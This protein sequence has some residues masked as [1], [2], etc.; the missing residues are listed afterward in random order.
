MGADDTKSIEAAVSRAWVRVLGAESLARQEEFD[1]AGG[2]SLAFLRL[3]HFIELEL[4]REIPLG[5]VGMS[6]T[7]ET[8]AAAIEAI[9]LGHGQDDTA[10][11]ERPVVFMVP[12]SGGDGPGQARLR[13]QC[14]PWLDMRTVR[15]PEWTAIMRPDFAF[16]SLCD[17]VADQID[18][19]AGAGPI[20]ITGYCFGG[21]VASIA[22][23][24]LVQRGRKVGYLGLVDADLAWFQR[25]PSR[26]HRTMS[27]IERLKSVRWA[28]QQGRLSEHLAWQAAELLEQRGR[29]VLRWM[30]RGNRHRVLPETFRFHLNLY[31]QMVL[32]P[33]VDRAGLIRLISDDHITAIPTTVFRTGHHAADRPDLGW[34]T[35]FDPVAVEVIQG[36]HNGVFD[37]ETIGSLGDQLVASVQRA[38]QRP[39]AYA[40]PVRNPV[41]IT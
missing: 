25:P 11:T 32:L 21:A 41:A 18:Q 3:M 2:D 8:L 33:R 4:D 22:A 30:A 15:L 24:K 5:Q 26:P 10:Q 9:L 16:E 34:K 7:A 31:L 23:R 12:V 38:I 36:D 28:W 39:P 20:L 40:P 17:S 14:A 6:D 19:G 35:L 29:G 27:G 13:A 37:P 1:A